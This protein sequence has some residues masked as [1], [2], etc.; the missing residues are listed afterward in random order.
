MA[1]RPGSLLQGCHVNGSYPSPMAISSTRTGLHVP[2][3]HAGRPA[4][5]VVGCTQGGPGGA[6]ASIVH[7]PVYMRSWA[8][9]YEGPAIYNGARISII[10][11]QIQ[12]LRYFVKRGHFEENC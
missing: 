9:I 6:I 10:I 4:S 8:S 7:G 12:V 5:A 3:D 2:V 1:V 11:L